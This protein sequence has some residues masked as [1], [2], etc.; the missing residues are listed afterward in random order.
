MYRPHFAFT[1]AAVP[2]EM[3]SIGKSRIGIVTLA[4]W[5]ILARLALYY[6][7]LCTSVPST[8]IPETARRCLECISHVWQK[9]RTLRPGPSYS[10]PRLVMTKR[11]SSTEVPQVCSRSRGSRNVTSIVTFFQSFYRHPAALLGKD[12]TKD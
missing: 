8:K 6:Q 11:Q 1:P 10:V 9:T 5:R 3:P 2:N 7:G 12:G 4:A